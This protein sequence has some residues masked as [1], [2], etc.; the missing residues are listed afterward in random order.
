[1]AWVIGIAVALVLYWFV[2]LR[3]GRV[4]FWR[5]VAKNP[6]AAYDHFR[7][8]V[9]W[10]IFDNELSEHYRT[11]VPSAEWDGPFRLWVPKRGGIGIYVFGRVPDYERSQ[12]EFMQHFGG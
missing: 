6:D 3:S 4:D 5:L 9:C 7:S 2:I 8:H 12:A 10:V 1:M 11:L